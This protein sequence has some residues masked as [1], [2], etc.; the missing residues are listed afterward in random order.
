MPIKLIVKHKDERHQNKGTFKP[1]SFNGHVNYNSMDEP[2]LESARLTEKTEDLRKRNQIPFKFDGEPVGE[3]AGRFEHW[4]PGKKFEVM[5]AVNNFAMSL[6]A[7][8]KV[9]ADMTE[10]VCVTD[11]LPLANFD[12]WE[13]LIRSQFSKVVSDTKHASQMCT[14]LDLISADGRKRENTLRTLCGGAPNAFF[15]CMALR[16]LNDWA[17][18]VRQAAKEQ[19][20]KIAKHS[21]PQDVANATIVVLVH[22]NSWGRIDETEKQVLLNIISRPQVANA[23]VAK[24]MNSSCGPMPSLFSQLSRTNI[25][26]T[27]LTNIAKSAIQPCIRAKAFRALFEKRLT[28]IHGREW[29]WTDIRYCEGQFKLI[30][31]ERQISVSLSSAELLNR[32]ARDA[33]PIVRRVAA[34]FLIR[35]LESLGSKAKRYAQGFSADKSNSVSERGRFALKMLSKT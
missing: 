12:Y 21:D 16:R 31:Y 26:D 9:I 8:G 2:N 27:H 18:Q 14:W 25:L 6:N 29:V 5:A 17:P 13:R 10:L 19:L 34:E 11:N 30:V 7:R 4:L 24:L 22:W 32:S 23:I 3:L 28:W 1:Y 20:A 35:E 15:L 33:S